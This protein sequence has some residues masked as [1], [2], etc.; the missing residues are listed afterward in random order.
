VGMCMHASA[1]AQ[2]CVVTTDVL[3]VEMSHYV[4]LGRSSILQ[5]CDMIS[6]S[7]A[8][9][10]KNL[11]YTSVPPACRTHRVSDSMHLLDFIVC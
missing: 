10:S 9:N 11:Q 2:G 3:G 8:G 5:F 7:I 4:F 6:I 1:M